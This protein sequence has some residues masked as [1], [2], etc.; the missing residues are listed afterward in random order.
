MSTFVAFKKYFDL[1]LK[2]QV[3]LTSSVYVFFSKVTVHIATQDQW[4]SSHYSELIC[5][6]PESLQFD[7]GVIL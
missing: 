1:R 3:Y 4:E 6:E 2:H 5:N 7:W